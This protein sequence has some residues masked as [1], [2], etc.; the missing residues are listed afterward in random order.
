MKR[1]VLTGLTI[2]L[3][4]AAA[5]CSSQK[6]M[7]QENDIAVQE[8]EQR[9]DSKEML[10][11]GLEYL[12]SEEKQDLLTIS[13]DA[14]LE[15]DSGKQDDTELSPAAEDSGKKCAVIYYSS[16]RM[17]EL[18]AEEVELE[19]LTPELLLQ[20]L[21]KHNVVSIDTKLLSFEEKESVQ[22]KYLYLDLSGAFGEYLKTMTHEAECI[23]LAAITDTYLDNYE[24]TEL[25]LTVEGET[26]STAYAAYQG[27]MKK[28]VPE[29]LLLE[30][31]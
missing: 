4:L 22:A 28:S 10:V 16:G 18:A 20:E 27:G 5:A 13:D 25:F 31:R 15:K 30:H 21:A 19:E 26:L 23:L 29:D 12:L 17:D 3:M 2:L 14:S 8:A 1:I 11:D 24:G 7:A 6:Q 9:A